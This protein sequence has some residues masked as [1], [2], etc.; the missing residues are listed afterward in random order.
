MSNRTV[1]TL[2]LGGSSDLLAAGGGAAL[3]LK[4]LVSLR[5]SAVR[6]VTFAV[7]SIPTVVA[8]P[9]SAGHFFMLRSAVLCNSGYTDI[10]NI[11][12]L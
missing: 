12:I 4:C 8:P 9:L 7:E 5:I 1:V 6:L 11:S 3:L 2:Y 10:C